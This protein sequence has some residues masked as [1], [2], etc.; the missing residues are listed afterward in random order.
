MVTILINVQ[1]RTRELEQGSNQ[2]DITKYGNIIRP[3]A[4]D[5]KYAESRSK[6]E[7]IQQNT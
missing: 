2:L 6:V 7:K 5:K 1:G 3:I 4:V